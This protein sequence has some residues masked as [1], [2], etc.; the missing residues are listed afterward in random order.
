MASSPPLYCDICGAANRAHARFCFACGQGL[1]NNAPSAFA[2]GG[3]AYGSTMPTGM[4]VSSHVLKQRYRITEQIGKGG[5]GAVYRAQDHEFD[6]RFVAVKEMSQSSLSPQEIIEATNAFRRESRILSSLTHPNLPRIYDNFS[7]SGR[8][9]LVMDFIEGQ[10]L[11][12]Y[13]DTLPQSRLPLDEA[14][15]IGIQLCTVLGYLHS[16]PMSII[17]RDLKPANVILTP[18]NHLYLID[19]GIARHFKP[20]QAK[21]TTAFGSAGY[22]APEQYGK[23]QTTPQAD[24][25]SL[26]ATLHQMVSGDDPSLSPFRFEPFK[27]RDPFHQQLEHLVMQMVQMD[28]S[29][30]PTSMADVKREL[31][32]ILAMRM[33]GPLSTIPLAS[34]ASPPAPQAPV[35][36]SPLPPLSPKPAGALAPQPIAA[37][38]AS[39]GTT[40]Q[41]VTRCTYRE[42]LRAVNALAWSPDS[43]RIASGASDGQ[44]HIWN[45]HTGDR[46][47]TCKGHKGPV[48]T[49]AWSLDGKRIASGSRDGTVRIWDAADGRE[50]LSYGGHTSY[51]HAVAWSPDGVRIAS[52]SSDKTVQVW[53][54][55]NSSNSSIYR[56]HSDGVKTVVWAPDGKR[57]ASGGKDKI[58]RV[59]QAPRFKGSSFFTNLF[60]YRG[61]FECPGYSSRVDA[62]S[63]SPD[64]RRIVSGQANGA[65]QVSDT[66][67]GHPGYCYRGHS[68]PVYTAAWSP[69]SKFVAS[70]SRD[71]TVHIWNATSGN[72]LFTYANH[73]SFILGVAWSPDGTRVASAS[74]DHTVQVWQVV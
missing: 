24:I 22:A 69:S 5:F 53:E 43:K 67:N 47:F 45:A 50:I 6:D 16:R 64:G 13:L 36:L 29:K 60:S 38:V 33:S 41:G 61:Q 72:R 21:D 3:T 42:H 63:W 51:V 70:G 52:A 32:R 65:A 9:Y 48:Y 11:E 7:D 73:S 62:I 37:P 54:V 25:Y 10:T 28:V 8:W 40:L 55:S 18:E 27:E 74:N 4:L 34:R 68:T 14:L 49:V 31:Q 12:D 39:P 44:I 35:P 2:S 30:R 15:D 59:W 71:G 17:F 19:F 46:F 26:G 57:L 23:S 1:Q 56:G 66:G 58:V 20:G